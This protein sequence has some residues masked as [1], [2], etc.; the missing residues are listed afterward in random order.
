[1]KVP[2]LL[3]TGLSTSQGYVYACGGNKKGVCERLNIEGNY[4]EKL[5]SYVEIDDTVTDMF[6]WTA[7]MLKP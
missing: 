7:V 4:W 5:P 3:S 2:K 6:T 1:M